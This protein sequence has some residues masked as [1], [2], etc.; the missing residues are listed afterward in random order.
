MKP[1][2]ISLEMCKLNFNWTIDGE[3][4]WK[5]SGRHRNLN[6]PLGSL[7]RTGYYEIK[8][9]GCTYR[10]HRILY[11]LYHDIE[12]TSEEFIDHIDRNPGNNSKNNLRIV[13]TSENGMNS[14]VQKNNKTT[15]IK[16]IYKFMKRKI[17]YYKI[18]ITKDRKSHQYNY[19]TSEYTLEEVKQIR[20]KLLKELHGEF[21]NDT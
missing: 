11:Q 13:N 2:F 17:E 4:Y 1:K 19:K 20:N 3:L 14:R 8:V 6:K 9:L 16:N 15:G 12:L 18:N 5:K 10:V 7:K 21:S